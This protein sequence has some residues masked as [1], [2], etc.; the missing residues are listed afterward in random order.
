[1]ARSM[2]TE[3]AVTRVADALVAEGAKPSV[4]AIRS[5]L[6]GGSYTTIQRC[7]EQWQAARTDAPTVPEVPLEIATKAEE[8][9]RALWATAS[10]LAQRETQV[11]RDQALAETTAAN[12]SLVEAQAEVERLEGVETE[13]R[14]ALERAQGH[15]HDLELRVAALEVNAKRVP[16][17]EAEIEKL[18]RES[19]DA[20][21]LR[22]SL[23]EMHKL[24]ATLVPRPEEGRETK[25]TRRKTSSDDED[26]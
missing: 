12:R 20:T 21:T 7:L 26:N 14:T 19:S 16:T 22:K 4:I 2:A 11:V 25:G 24:L 17:L 6:G 13:L 1:M 18:R 15:A 5:R 8:S 23:E 10:A 9:V 3:E